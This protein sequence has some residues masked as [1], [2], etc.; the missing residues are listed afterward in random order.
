[1]SQVARHR[2]IWLSDI[3]LGS[4]ACRIDL[5]LDF[6]ERNRCERLYLVGDIIDLRRM[7]RSFY[8]PKTHTVALERMLAMARAGTRVIFVPGNH[9]EDFRALCGSRLGPVEVHREFVHRTAD[10]KRLLVLHGDCFD[11]AIRCSALAALIGGAGYGL[12]LA[13]N[14][15]SHAVNALFRRPYWSL[16]QAVK[17]RIGRAAKYVDRFQAACLHAAR[18]AGVDGVVTGHIH[19]AALLERDG[20]LYCNDGDWVESC[21]ALVENAAGEL[22][23]LH[24]GQSL[25][26]PATALPEP[27]RDAA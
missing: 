11:S 8:W 7:R 26:V 20:L 22:S 18:E 15:I 27:L 9:D 21:T 3:H 24:W 1:M 17:M 25:A 14:R 13:L 16:A 2:T 12:L 10:G 6:L 23:L 4:R 5:L 19:R